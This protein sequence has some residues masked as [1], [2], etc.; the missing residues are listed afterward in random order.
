VETVGDQGDWVA[1][2]NRGYVVIVPETA[3]GDDLTVK[4][5]QVQQNVAFVTVVDPDYLTL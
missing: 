4:I 2:V 3:P 1:K 5:K